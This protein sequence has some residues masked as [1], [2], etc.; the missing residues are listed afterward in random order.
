MA[1]VTITVANLSPVANNDTYSATSGQT[2]LTSMT[3]G[4]QA[5]DTDPGGGGLSS[6]LVANVQHG[7]L[8]F[9]PGGVFSYTPAPGFSG[10]D[11]FTYK[12][13]DGALTSNV[14]TVTITV[15]AATQTPI[16][17]AAAGS[18]SSGGTGSSGSAAGAA[19][20]AAAGAGLV[21]FASSAARTGS[22]AAG[23]VPTG[24]GALYSG[25]AGLGS[26]APT[27]VAAGG[28]GAGFH[29]TGSI[30]AGG[31]GSDGLLLYNGTLAYGEYVPYAPRAMD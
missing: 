7:T 12:D 20:L 28:T 26:L 15:T 22:A 19:S 6:T 25:F 30:V 23:S 9:Q 17:S 24:P 8:T 18:G 3:Q 1:T 27:T 2:L 21:P 5:N 13:S 11:S 29:G 14:A 31:G 16:A 10:T 4:V